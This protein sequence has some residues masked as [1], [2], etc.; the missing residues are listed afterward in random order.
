[1]CMFPTEVPACSP[2]TDTVNYIDA[3]AI[4]CRGVCF[5]PADAATHLRARGRPRRLPQGPQAP[6]AAKRRWRA[7]AGLLQQ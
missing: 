1:M 4:S 6:E 2:Q 5:L 3:F 7:A